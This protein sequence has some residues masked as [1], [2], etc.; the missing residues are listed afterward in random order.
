[1]SSKQNLD[2]LAAARAQNANL[3]KVI[4]VISVLSAMGMFYA[5]SLPKHLELHLAPDIKAGSQLSVTDG[6]SPVPDTNVYSFAYYIWQQINRWQ[7]DGSKDYGQQIYRLQA[8]LT[9]TCRAQLQSDLQ[10]RSDAGELR[11]RTRQMTEIP[12]FG[13]ASNRVVADGPSAWTV[14]IDMQLMESFRGQPV[15]DAFI[16]YPIR[17]VRYDV[18]RE[19][20]PWRLAID[21]YGAHR[22]ARLDVRDVQAVTEGKAEAELP[23]AVTPSALPRTTGDAVDP[24][25]AP[26]AVPLQRVP[27]AADPASQP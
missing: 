14:L 11:M 15:K 22:P 26:E 1:M 21:C 2:A 4:G 25:A 7:A 27:A 19:R 13:F 3:L 24:N 6:Q 12:G 8:Y 17:V 23:G 20:N 10:A 5:H 16:R 9:P 18:D